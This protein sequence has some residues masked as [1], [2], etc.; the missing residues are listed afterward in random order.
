MALDQPGSVHR[1]VVFMDDIEFGL[2]VSECK[3][4]HEIELT[5]VD[6]IGGLSVGKEIGIEE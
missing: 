5:R 6:H 2:V 4:E 3:P 1:K